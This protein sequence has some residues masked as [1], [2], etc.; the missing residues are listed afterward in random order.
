MQSLNNLL[1]CSDPNPE[2]GIGSKLW[3]CTCITHIYP[4]KLRDHQISILPAPRSR[5]HLTPLAAGQQKGA[6]EGKCRPEPCR[7]Q[8]FAWDVKGRAEDVLRLGVVD[9]MHGSTD[10]GIYIYI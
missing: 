4:N 5:H 1:T 8:G 6:Q 10:H 9:G 7:D 2:F 3:Y